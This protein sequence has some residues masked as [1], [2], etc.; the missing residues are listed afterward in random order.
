MGWVVYPPAI[1]QELKQPIRLTLSTVC[2]ATSKF[3]SQMLFVLLAVL[4]SY[5]GQKLSTPFHLLQMR[6][7][8]SDIVSLVSGM[9]VYFNLKIHICLNVYVLFLMTQINDETQL[10]AVPRCVR[11]SW[12]KLFTTIGIRSRA[13]QSQWVMLN[14]G[15]NALCTTAHLNLS[16]N[17]FAKAVITYLSQNCCISKCKNILAVSLVFR[18]ALYMF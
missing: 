14:S 2:K 17:T 8:D 4:H 12:L 5:D 15:Y 16:Q 9:F 13:I 10:P 18:P 6:V 11:I 1:W 7:M 3:N